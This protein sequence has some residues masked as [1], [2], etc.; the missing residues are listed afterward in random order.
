MYAEYLYTE[1]MYIATVPNR[2]SPP[3]ICF[4]Y[5]EL[6][7]FGGLNWPTLAANGYPELGDAQKGETVGMESQ[8]GT[9]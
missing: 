9:I 3:A 5:S 4:R 6:A 1:V 2:N 7:Q 8:G